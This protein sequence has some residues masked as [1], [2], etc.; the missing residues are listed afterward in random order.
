MRTISWLVAPVL[1]ALSGCTTQFSGEAHVV[2]GPAGCERKCAA[3]NEEFVG[4]VAMGEYSDAC[5]CHVPGAKP[6]TPAD[7]ATPA[8]GAA[9]TI[10][11]TDQQQQQTVNAAPR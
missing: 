9:G 7:A 4:M 5:I 6:V 8:A 1:L 11:Q 2:G 3:W 10:M